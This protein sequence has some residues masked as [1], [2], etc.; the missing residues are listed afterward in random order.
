MHAQAIY[1]HAIT[2]LHPGT[3]QGNHV[4][5]LP[6][7]REVATGWPFV[8]GSTVKGVYAAHCG[9]N[10]T[11]RGRNENNLGA[12][13]GHQLAQDDEKK[14]ASD[15]GEQSTAKETALG[16]EETAPDNAGSLMFTDLRILALPVRSLWGTFAW[17]T[18]PSVLTRWQADLGLA[19]QQ[20][21][22]LKVP[23]LTVDQICAGQ[24]LL[25]GK[26]VVLEDLEL[27]QTA[28]A[29]DWAQAIAKA[30]LTDEEQNHFKER[31][32]VV[33]DDV[34]NFLCQTALEIRTRIAI[35]PKTGIVENGHLWTEESLPSETLLHGLVCCEAVYGSTTSKPEGLLK[36]FCKPDHEVV[37]QIGGKASTGKGLARVR[38]LK[39]HEPNTDK[40]EHA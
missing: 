14:S 1:L 5:D 15:N 11:R 13:F 16:I 3:G 37:L 25:A 30:V 8:P 31:F 6:V 18:C 38:G 26:Q 32:A 9:A 12:A 20:N 34:F 10:K 40:K 2:P 36:Q 33:S 39:R 35:N 27:T 29:A 24:A 17:I 19:G 22:Q 23:S 4:V 21:S 28:A 7:V